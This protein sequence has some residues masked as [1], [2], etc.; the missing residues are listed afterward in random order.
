MVRYRAT[1]RRRATQRQAA[2]AARRQAAW[3]T[4]QRAAALLKADYGVDRVTLFGSLSRDE[5]FS[6]HSDIDLAV[7]GLDE[8]IYYRAVSRL[9]DI[10]P[11]LSIDLLRAETLNADLLHMLETTGITL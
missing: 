6:P 5:P 8:R 4:A 11:S 1:A 7:W 9:L 10:D 3:E 2:L